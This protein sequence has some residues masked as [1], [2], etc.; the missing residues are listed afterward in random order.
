MFHSTIT[1]A[2]ESKCERKKSLPP[3]DIAICM[4][5]KY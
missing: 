2:S 1:E 3:T 5:F 4:Y